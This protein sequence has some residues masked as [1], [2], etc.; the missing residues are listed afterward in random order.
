MDYDAN[1]LFP[2][3]MWDENSGNPKIENGFAF[4]PYTNNVYV[5]A[6]NNETFNQSCDESAILLIK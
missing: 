3:T 2:S 4:K 1:S 6:I 5:E